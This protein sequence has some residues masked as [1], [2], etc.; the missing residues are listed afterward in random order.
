[1]NNTIKCLTDWLHEP[2]TLLD[3]KGDILLLITV[4][5][6]Y[7]FLFMNLYNPFNMTALFTGWKWE[8]SVIFFKFSL[9]AVFTLSFMEFV[10][11]PVLKLN[12][13]SRVTFI[14]FLIFELVVYSVAMFFLFELITSVSLVGPKDLI[15]IFRYSILVM[16]IP[17]SG[18]LF[19]FHHNQIV[20]KIPSMVNH[21]IR[22][23]DE[24]GKLHLAVNQYQLLAIVA[25]DN[26]VL[27]YYEK[28][29]S[30]G[31]ELIRTSLKKLE[32]Q[33]VNTAMVRFS[34]SA[35]VN[36]KNIKS[37]KTQSK[38]LILDINK[39]PNESIT[40]SRNYKSIVLGILT[41]Q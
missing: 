24:N 37:S 30:L 8:Y 6:I 35:M 29:G 16:A 41:N 2:F 21:L 25:A 39:M 28:D 40:V 31:K 34:R 7:G 5:G 36:I 4:I 3:R 33:L 19:Y 17:Y 20:S 10:I 1:M 15:D 22:I 9:L 13:L 11:R 26:Y 32:K 27:I 12:N 14:L 38:Q 23:K 18:M